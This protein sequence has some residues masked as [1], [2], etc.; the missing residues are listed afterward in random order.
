MPNKWDRRLRPTSFSPPNWAK[1]AYCAND[2]GSS[3]LKPHT[4]VFNINYAFYYS[5]VAVLLEVNDTVSGKSSKS[6][7]QVIYI[8]EFH[9]MSDY[10]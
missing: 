6:F 8:P 7:P 10:D 3:S 2:V 4:S 1:I 9:N 5:F